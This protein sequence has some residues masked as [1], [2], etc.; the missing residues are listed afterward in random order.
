MQDAA[1]AENDIVRYTVNADRTEDATQRW[2]DYK[3]IQKA[4]NVL[5]GVAEASTNVAELPPF[6]RSSAW[7]EVYGALTDP[8]RFLAIATNAGVLDARAAYWTDYLQ[9]VMS[10]G[11]GQALPKPSATYKVYKDKNGA[12]NVS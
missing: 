11:K 10:Y 3:N 2:Y 9:K 7:S 6:V 12:Q 1:A 8:P 4:V 5:G